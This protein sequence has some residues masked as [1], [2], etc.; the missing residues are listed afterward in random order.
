[1]EEDEIIKIRDLINVVHSTLHRRSEPLSLA[2]EY[3]RMREGITQCELLLLRMNNFQAKFD[4]PHKY[5]LLQL[6]VICH[7]VFR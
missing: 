6:K 1:M 4:H 3:Y 5:L 7:A 2:E